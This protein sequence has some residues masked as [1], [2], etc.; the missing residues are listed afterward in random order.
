MIELSFKVI[1]NSFKLV[2]S[3]SKEFI[4]SDFV[5][6]SFLSICKLDTTSFSESSIVAIPDVNLNVL[7]F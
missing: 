1:E 2:V 5:F 6:P 7:S 4:I 3:L